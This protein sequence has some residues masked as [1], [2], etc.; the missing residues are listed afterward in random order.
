M[1]VRGVCF[2]YHKY[3]VFHGIC[4]DKNLVGGYIWV[5]DFLNLHIGHYVTDCVA[6]LQTDR[7]NVTFI[8]NKAFV[9]ALK[10][11]PQVIHMEFHS[12]VYM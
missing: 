9:S 4:K 11:T 12:Y 5:P 7:F 6:P 2:Y 10:K 8:G 1:S 3:P